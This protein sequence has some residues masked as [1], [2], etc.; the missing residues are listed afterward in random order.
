MSNF[1]QAGR[2]G[3]GAIL[4][5]GVASAA[6][7]QPADAGGPSP[8]GA[9]DPRDARIN[10][11]EAELQDLASEVADLKRGQAAQ[12]QTIAALPPKPAASVGFSNG[13]PTITSADG[14]FSATFHGVMQFD[15]ANYGQSAIGPT[16]SDFRRDGPAIGSSAANVDAAHARNLK[17]GDLFRRARIGMDGTVYKD[18]DYRVLFDFAGSGVE[19]V[20]QLYE[21]WVQYNGLKPFHARVGAFSPSIGLEDQGSTNGM[22]FLERPGASDTAR[23]LAAGDT[24]T[25]AQLFG[26]GDRWFASVAV[27]GRTIGVVST[28]ATVNVTVP[29]QTINVP[30]GGGPVTIPAQTIVSSA[31]GTAQTYGDQLGIVGRLAGTPF[32]GSDWLIH[33]GVHGSYVIDPANT[34]GPATNGTTPLS[35]RT[36]SLSDTP[37]LRVDGTK[38]INTGNIQAKHADTV[39]LEFAAQKKN[40]FLQSEWEH[41]DIQRADIASTPSFSGFYIEGSW[42]LTGEARKYNTATA[43]FDA[44]P[45]DHPFNLHGGGLGAWELA[46][47]YSDM[48][49]NYHAGA[50]GSAPA[51]DAI[52]GGDQ[53]I[54]SAGLNWYLN[55]VVRFMFDYQRVTINRLSPNASTYSTT[56]GAQI[57]QSYNA[58]AVRSQVAF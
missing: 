32:R 7:S 26:Y 41:F 11:L 57:G 8:A 37:E 2:I 56:T 33:L 38:F 51:A 36:V 20:G 12:I 25:A 18:F 22:P 35:A 34:A 24:R 14:N 27:T 45:V 17:D 50:P 15:A 43:A 3:L 29:A 30:A 44:P 9:V 55:P 16:S 28:G 21:A 49:L 6:L 58:F 10:Q 53:S 42:I 19:N 54:W 13:R 52:R 48:N 31:I 47:R 5:A 1:K 4:F 40:F 23:A 46:L 39:G